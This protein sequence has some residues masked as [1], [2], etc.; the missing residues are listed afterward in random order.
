MTKKTRWMMAG[1]VAVAAT[2]LVGS[3][4][5]ADDS[6]DPGDYSVAV[7]GAGEVKV[8]VDGTGVASLVSLPAGLAMA[9]G[10]AA[11]GPSDDVEFRLR[12]SAGEEF[13]IKVEDGR[14]VVEIEGVEDRT[15]TTA[16]GSTV[17]DDDDTT[18]TTID[19]STSTTLD[20]DD[21]TTS[22]TIDDS[23]STTV[24][25]STTSTTIDDSTSTT[26]DD[27]DDGDDDDGGNTGSGK[28]SGG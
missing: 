6:V 11:Q 27:D 2:L 14:F 13:K 17:A 24:G 28:G 5:F 8:R 25:S 22:T 16:P 23:T 7:P 26:I 12:A 18:S 4:A 20:D 3:L 21:D 9:P 10:G 15:S 1:S 19:D